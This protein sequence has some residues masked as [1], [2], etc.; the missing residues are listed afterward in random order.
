MRTNLDNP[1]LSSKGLLLKAK[2][3][4]AKVGVIIT[5][6]AVCW[7]GGLKQNLNDK[8]ALK[9]AQFCEIFVRDK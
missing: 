3:L 4:A 6:A 8:L 7:G 1:S 5:G 2:L 9:S